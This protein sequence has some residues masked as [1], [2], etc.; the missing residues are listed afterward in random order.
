LAFDLG[1]YQDVAFFV[2][3]IAAL[4][5]G[6]QFLVRGAIGLGQT[7]H[8]SPL[9][10]GLVIV[11]MGSSAPELVVAL[12]AMRAGQPDIAVGNVVG[13]NITNVLLILGLAALIYPLAIRRSM[14]FRDAFVMLLATATF[15]W[16]AQ[17]SDQF[18]PFHG[19]I[20]VGILVIYVLLSFVIEQVTETETGD[21]VRALAMSHR[22]PVALIPLDILLVAGGAA[23]LVYG[24]HFTVAGAAAFASRLGVSEAV[25][26]LSVVAIGTSLPELA[27]VLIAALQHRTQIVVGNILGSNIFNIL[28]VIGI[29][30]L[31]QPIDISA[32]IA[33]TD[34][35]IM[36][37][38]A[39]VLLPFM[40]TN[41]QLS[42]GEG[43][44]LVIFYFIYIGSLYTGLG[45]H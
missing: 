31:M 11:A 41:W 27:T 45:V 22:L 3:G 16:I 21:R 33:H 18:T 12:A 39:V 25:I 13:S 9:F 20:L 44:V 1:P 14:V 30:A 36:L 10:T 6:G 35:W 26:G 23:L 37:A 8:L 24:A 4:I 28:T 15:V 32:R 17:Y 40:I 2:G 43:L 29:T 19:I 38:S 7:F 42:R 34:M 5:V